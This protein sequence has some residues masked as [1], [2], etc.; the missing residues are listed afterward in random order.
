MQVELSPAPRSFCSGRL[1]ALTWHGC[2][3]PSRS[4]SLPAGDRCAHTSPATHQP[5]P[6]NSSDFTV[7]GSGVSQV[8]PAELTWSSRRAGR[9]AD[10]QNP[11]G[12]LQVCLEP[13]SDRSTPAAILSRHPLVTNS[14]PR[15]R[16]T[17]VLGL[18]AAE[19]TRPV[20]KSALISTSALLQLVEAAGAR[21]RR[22]FSHAVSTHV[23]F[24]CVRQNLISCCAWSWAKCSRL[25]LLLCCTSA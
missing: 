1:W 8:W 3:I 18:G 14:L 23:S 21:I 17:Q 19:T 10:V 15:A 20:K 7:L 6:E 12:P 11:H 5:S 2:A 13:P 22:R 9:V 25:C 24:K 4:R 16:R